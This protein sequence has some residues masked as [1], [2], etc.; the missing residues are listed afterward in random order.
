MTDKQII[1]N[2]VDVSE[3]KHF[4]NR[5]C[6][7]DYLLTDMDFSE[8]KCELCKDC[9]FKQ[10]AHKTQEC[11]G[12]KEENFTFEQLIKEYE[13]YG[14]I[15]E[16]IE[17][18]DQLKVAKEQAEHKLKRIKDILQNERPFIDCSCGY[19]I[20]QIVDEV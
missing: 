15:E 16:I 12:L 13:K 17:Q 20:L 10:L 6:L 11:E 4:K 9:Y 8:A 3:C 19:D 18:L 7:A 1:S 5:T 2:G 14:A